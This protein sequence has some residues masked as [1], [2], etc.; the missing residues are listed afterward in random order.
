MTK[1]LVRLAL[2]ACALFFGPPSFGQGVVQ[3]IGSVIPGDVAVWWQ[4]GQVADS[5]A[6]P[7]WLSSQIDNVAGSA[8]G[9]VLCRGASSWGIS[10]PSATNMVLQSS[11]TGCPAWVTADPWGSGTPVTGT[12]NAVLATSP[13]LVT[14]TL[15]TPAITNGTISG[16]TISGSTI[17]SA[18]ISSSTFSSPTFTTPTISGKLTLSAS[19][20]SAASVNIPQGIAPTSPGNGDCWTTSSGLYCYIASATQGPF[21]SNT[22]TVTSVGLSLPSSILTVSGSPVTASGTLSATLASQT[23]NT[24]FSAPNGSSGSPTFRSLVATDIVGGSSGQVLT[25]NG[26]GGA[27]FASAPQNGSDTGMSALKVSTLGLSNYTSTITAGSLTLR[28]SAGTSAVVLSTVS[29]TPSI[30]ASGAN[31]LDTGSLTAS[32]WYYDYVIYNPTTLTTAGLFSASYTSPTLPSGYTFYVR[33]GAVRSDSS[34]NKY[35]LQTLQI[36]NRARYVLLWSSNISALPAMA[37]GVLGS[38]GTPTWS[39][40]AVAN[41]VPP[42]ASSIQVV[43]RCQSSNAMAAPNNLYGA[44]NGTSNPP[45]VILAIGTSNTAAQADFLIESANIYYAGDGAYDGLYAGG[46]QDNL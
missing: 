43:L 12:G 15:T 32:T 17:S 36:G 22:G 16:S 13:T 25:S 39:A 41:F 44:Y 5:S 9:S 11:T 18:T 31:G 24:V 37:T 34:A 10:T 3:Q 14:P 7:N 40:A 4:N 2:F 28:N 6:F 35:L 38:P 8:P 23:A 27:S 21:T 20:T 1:T 19:T 46:W 30:S 45:P 42:T 29:V 33:V 26:S